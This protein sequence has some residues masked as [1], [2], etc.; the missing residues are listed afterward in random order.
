MRPL[1]PLAAAAAT[2]SLAAASLAVAAAPAAAA[3]W[4]APAT[5][6][7][8]HTFVF[9]LEAGSS[10]D[11]S[12]VADWGFQDGTGSVSTTGVR[13]ATLAPGAAAFAGE[14]TLPGDTLRVIP[15]ARRS[16]AALIFTR[17]FA[18]TRDRL[19]VAFGSVDGPSLGAARTVAPE[20]TA[21][22]PSFAMASD[23]TGL[24]AWI[25]RASGNRRVVKLSLRAD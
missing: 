5:V 10:A 14:R 25:S 8:P 12:V 11:G 7:T 18:T 9:G 22:L 16:V 17:A 15:Y 6:S 21:F 20:D 23:G 19:A 24:L 1:R 2:A 4:T 3:T 13:G